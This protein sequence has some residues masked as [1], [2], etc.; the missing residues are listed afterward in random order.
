MKEYQTFEKQSLK[1]RALATRL[2]RAM[3][4]EA[5]LKHFVKDPLDEMFQL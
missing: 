4:S 3:L 2:K 5:A 1:E